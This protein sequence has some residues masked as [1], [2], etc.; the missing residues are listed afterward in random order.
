M[1]QPSDRFDFIEAKAEMC[2]QLE[3][4]GDESEA[5]DEQLFNIA[6]V[7]SS[8]GSLQHTSSGITVWFVHPHVNMTTVWD[9]QCLSSTAKVCAWLL[10][11]VYDTTVI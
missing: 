9:Q 8:R 6:V 10:C 11:T 3:H 7:R 1:K 5:R 4:L 2:L